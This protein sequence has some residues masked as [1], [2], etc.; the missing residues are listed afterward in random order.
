MKTAFDPSLLARQCQAWADQEIQFLEQVLAGQRSL[1]QAIGRGELAP[2]AEDRQF[3][4]QQDFLVQARGVERQRLR[5]ALSTALDLPEEQVNLDQV[6]AA[7]S[8][9]DRPTLLALRNRVRGLMGELAKV[10]QANQLFASYYQDFIQRFL[11]DL[12]GGPA[13]G[14][15][16]GPDGACRTPACGSLLQAQG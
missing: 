8:P 2:W 16:Y 9:S 11:V 3:Q 7:V 5:R 6:V 4:E 10:H 14:R 12:T 1:R 15:R 13:V